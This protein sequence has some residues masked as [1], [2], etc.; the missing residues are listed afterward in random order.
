MK[1]I[2]EAAR[3]TSVFAE[4]DVLV[5]GGGSA[6]VAAAV[7]AARTGARVLLVERYGYL[8]GLA[9]GGLVITV[10]PLDNGIN[11]EI[12]E[13]LERAD[14]YRQGENLGD[15]PSVDGLIA[16]DPELLKHQFTTMLLGAGVDL[17]LHTYIAQAITEDGAV[18][19]V[20]VENKAGRS[21][22]LAKVVVDVTGDGDVAASA[23]ADF[24]MEKRP[25][26]VTLMANVGGV[27]RD[28]AIEQLGHWGN[29]RKLVEEGVESGELEFDLEIHT[30]YYA[31]GVFAADLC[32]P[33]EINLW[34]GSMFGVDGLDPRQLTLAEIV[35]REHAM[36]LVHFLKQRLRGFEGSWLEYTANQIG[37][38]ETRRIVGGCSPTLREALGG[39]CADT[40]AKPYSRRRMR[41]PFGSLVPQTVEGLL[42]AGRCMS[43]QQ[44]AMV[45]LRLIPVCLATGQ[46]AGTAAALA[47][48]GGVKPRDVDVARLQRALSSQGV[49]LGVEE[50]AGAAERS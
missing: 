34:P 18:T 42:V 40:V 39:T 11:S 10:P 12:R 2:T 27:D 19:G 48:D 8:G 16:V 20:I 7:C 29:L 43:A 3:Q 33:G 37:V 45:Q 28:K 44:D 9:T 15:D 38:R 46:A 47:A 49:D 24:A 36:R 31:P 26:P 23:G 41:I 17:L 22:I 13:K 32:H 25:L 30:K 5:C 1:H 35:T 50:P 6:G 21:A 4:V 14:V